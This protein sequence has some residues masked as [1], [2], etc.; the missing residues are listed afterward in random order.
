MYWDAATGSDS[1]QE[2]K[3]DSTLTR[4]PCASRTTAPSSS[5]ATPAG[6]MT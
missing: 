4:F 6:V 5:S 3:L 1:N 2:P